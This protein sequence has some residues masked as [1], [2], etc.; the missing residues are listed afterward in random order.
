MGLD[1]EMGKGG[2]E[3]LPGGVTV[4]GRGSASEGLSGEGVEELAVGGGEAGG[5]LAMMSPTGGD[6]GGED[7]PEEE[8]EEYP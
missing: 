3:G 5:W 2:G 6:I 1:T 4:K 8:E 7:K